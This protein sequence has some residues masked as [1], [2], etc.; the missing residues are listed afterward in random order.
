[1]LRR[2]LERGLAA[3]T[4]ALR[5]QARPL[6]GPEQI[7]RAA[8]TLC[9][10]A[11]LAGML[12]EILDIVGTDGYVQVETLYAPGLERQYVEGIHCNEGYAS[13]YFITDEEKQEVRLELPLILIS[14]LR[15]TAAE[16][17]VPLLD[18]LV[19]ARCP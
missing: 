10:D 19:E 14:D 7:A 6:E 13:A 4:A 16:E 11:E 15:I 8:E 9:H 3:A 5:E 1:A 17:L 12:G 2:H 18:R